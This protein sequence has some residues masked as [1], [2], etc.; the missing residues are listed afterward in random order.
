MSI[1]AGRTELMC[2]LLFSFGLSC[3]ILNEL[4]SLCTFC[5]NACKR[6]VILTW[7]HELASPHVSKSGK[8]IIVIAFFSSCLTNII[9]QNHIGW[10]LKAITLE[11]PTI[12]EPP[13]NGV[14]THQETHVNYFLNL[15]TV[16]Q[17]IIQIVDVATLSFSESSGLCRDPGWQYTT[18]QD[19]C[20]PVRPHHAV[21]VAPDPYQLVWLIRSYHQISWAHGCPS[22]CQDTVLWSH[23]YSCFFPPPESLE[24]K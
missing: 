23:G 12:C 13:N 16:N 24:S 11:V 21:S 4:E 2:S 3:W 15:G 10:R 9:R 22:M 7:R 8:V 1:L 5:R 19:I 6:C 18:V 20:P 14:I 17:V